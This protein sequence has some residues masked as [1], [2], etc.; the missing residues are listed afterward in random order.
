[1]CSFEHGHSAESC[2]HPLIS[3]AAFFRALV[4]AEL[5]VGMNDD[6]NDPAPSMRFPS[7]R[8]ALLYL[9]VL[10]FLVIS[11]GWDGVTEHAWRATYPG[12]ASAAACPTDPVLM[13]PVLVALACGVCLSWIAHRTARS[14]A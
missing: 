4:R 1:M 9:I 12:T 7:R 5:L 13:L 10:A 8:H 2:A 14:L 3:V 6:R 11:V